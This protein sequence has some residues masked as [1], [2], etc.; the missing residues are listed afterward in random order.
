MLDIDY[1]DFRTEISIETPVELDPAT[2]KKCLLGNKTYRF[3]KRYSFLT[4]LIKMT[5]KKE[6]HHI[7]ILNHLI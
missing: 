2:L 6:L 5:E 1:F 3:K 4:H 7:G